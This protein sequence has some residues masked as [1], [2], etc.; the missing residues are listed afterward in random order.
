M[1][2]RFILSVLATLLMLG[3]AY[4]QQTESLTIT[5]YYPSPYGSYNELSTNIFN[6]G[7]QS[8]RPGNQEGRLYYDSN[9]KSIFYYN[10]TQWMEL[11]GGGEL[12]LA[13]LTKSGDHTLP[14]TTDWR[15]IYGWGVSGS[16]GSLL[17]DA[18]G[19]Y[20]M[21]IDLSGFGRGLYEI[22]WAGQVEI[23][24]NEGKYMQLKLQSHSPG[25]DWF[26]IDAGEQY[27]DADGSRDNPDGDSTSIGYTTHDIEVRTA[28]L[29][30]KQRNYQDFRII[31]R[32][33]AGDGKAMAR[34]KGGT[35]IV[36]TR[37][38]SF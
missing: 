32:K 15:R 27:E 19:S 18:T 29:M 10:G 26:T 25:G 21:R 9:T 31:A 28:T 16:Y 36:V 20:A 24:A 6:L 4:A 17:S 35:Y 23:D 12:I 38:S 30:L 14:N 11:G 7:P 22:A 3:L 8:S 1:F 33:N 2:K 37:V 34:V 13:T 5:T